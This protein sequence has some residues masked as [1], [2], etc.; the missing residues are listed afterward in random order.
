MTT[1]FSEGIRASSIPSAASPMK[2][3]RWARREL[4]MLVGMGTLALF[5]GIGP[6]RLTD[7]G[8]PALAGLV[9]A[10]LFVVI[11]WAA[12]GVMR[13]ADHLASRLGEPLGTLVLTL[14]A[15]SI[16]VSLIAALALHGSENPT[17]ARDTMFAVLMIILNGLVGIALLV[18]ALRHHLQ[19]FNPEGTRSFLAIIMPLAVVSMVLPNHTISSPEGTLTA[20]QAS[21]FAMFTLLLYGVFLAVQ[22]RR[23]K[24]FF[25]ERQGGKA[26]EEAL[27]PCVGAITEGAQQRST[28]YHSVLLFL[29]LLPV[30]LLA[31]NLAVVVEDGIVKVGAPIGLAG[32][33]IAA[34]VLAPEG[35]SA[36][37]SAWNNKLQRAI[38]LM[39]G[40]A[41]STIAITIPA[42]VFLGLFTGHHIVL[43][44]DTRNVV[45][46]LL[47]LTL[48]MITFGGDRTDMLKGAVHLV[49]FLVFIVL[50][51]AP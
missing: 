13:H 2:I 31:E 36:V 22:T 34:L 10:W 3:I 8:H 50:V 42:V 1:A 49:L 9:F 41:L 15:V 48:S 30:P 24:L 40:S 11:L 43:G 27:E 46:L 23:H 18:G 21:L 45:L 44:L 26:V 14:S 6:Q 32:I 47:T 33:I 38:N 4:P 25:Q 16:E 5:F 29:T 37:H 20:A 17:L 7:V 39:L 12:I 51:I 28:L 19:D 35:L